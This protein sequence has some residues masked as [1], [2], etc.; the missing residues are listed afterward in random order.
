MDSFTTQK[1]MVATEDDCKAPWSGGKNGKN[2]R[3][4]FCGHK[5]FPGDYYRWIFTNNTPGAG[6]NP[7][8]CKSC[9][10]GDRD[11]MVEKWKSL[12]KRAREEDS[13]MWWFRKQRE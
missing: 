3:C 10:D 8:T 9:D 1:P 11:K 5:F 12:C 2:F 7:L 6:G 4:Y 13:T